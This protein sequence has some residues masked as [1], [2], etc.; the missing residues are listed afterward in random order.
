MPMAVIPI[1]RPVPCQALSTPS[2]A[3]AHPFAATYRG[4][5]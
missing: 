4:F 2:L 1:T 3:C 5:Q